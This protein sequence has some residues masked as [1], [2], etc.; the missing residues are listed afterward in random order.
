MRHFIN[1]TFCIVLFLVSGAA[2]SQR[3]ADNYP[4]RS[5]RFVVPLAAGG[6][7]DIISRLFAQKLTESWGQQ[8]VVDNRP[9]AGGLIGAQIAATA[10]ADGYTM[11]M[12]SSSFTVL[13]SMYS[14]MPY[15]TERDFAPVSRLITFPFLL[16]TYPSVQAKSAKELI[17]MANAKPGS[18]NYASGGSGSAAHLAAELFKSLSASNF[19]HVPYK[20]TGAAITAILSGEVAFGFYSESST[21]DYIKAGRLKV[22][23]STAARR[24]ASLP[25]VPT[26]AESALPGY[27]ASTWAGVLFPSGTPGVIIKK[28]HADLI[29]ILGMPDMKDKIATLSFQPVGSSPE[30]FAA[31][32]KSEIVKWG[33]V[34]RESGAKVE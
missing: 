8:L 16:V 25:D 17:A 9:G 3:V 1:T 20:G 18:I 2:F 4:S 6:G 10:P 24:S 15:D 19:T 11:M 27:E 34:V 23:A 28:L 32:I 30:E 26:I 33:K 5:I 22:L 21:R 12:V 14:K 31:T 13:P 7:T 29:R